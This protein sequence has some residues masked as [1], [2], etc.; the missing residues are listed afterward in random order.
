MQGNYMKRLLLFAL[1]LLPLI[2]NAEDM[3]CINGIYYKFSTEDNS[4]LT[5]VTALKDINEE[6]DMANIVIPGAL[7][8][9]G[10]S[11]PV[12]SISKNA[13]KKHP[14]ETI[15]LWDGIETIGVTAFGECSH[16]KSIS[17]PGSVTTIGDAAF[18]GC[19]SLESIILPN[20]INKIGDNLFWGCS[21]LSNVTLPQSLT[22]IGEE[23][24]RECEALGSIT[25]PDGV[26]DIGKNAFQNCLK[27]TDVYCNAKN[28]PKTDNTAFAGTPIKSATLHVPAEAVEAYR[29]TLPWSDF[30]EI[31]PLNSSTI[32][33][34]GIY[35]AIKDDGTLEVTGLATSVTRADILSSVTVN[36][37]KYRV[38]SIAERAFE[39]RSDLTYLSVPYSVKSIGKY[40]FM[41]C[42][43]KVAVNIADPESWCQMELGNES[44]SPLS[45]AGK[46]LVF[47]TE[48]SQVTIPNSVTSINAF[49]FYQC[50]CIKSLKIPAS[51]TSIGSSAF[52]GCTKLKTI[53]SEIQQPFA[54]DENVFSTWSTATLI[55]PAGKKSAYKSA[56]GWNQFTHIVEVGAETI[57]QCGQNA[58]YIYDKSAQTLTVYGE[59]SMY[60]F[61]NSETSSGFWPD[62]ISSV[63]IEPGV[64]AIGRFDFYGN[65]DLTSIIIPSSVTSIG[66]SA[67][68]G[69]TGLRSVCCL[70]SVPPTC[71]NSFNPGDDAILW[72]PQGC[73]NAYKGWQGF[74]NIRELTRGDVN[75]DFN[76]N[77]EDL[78]AT[79]NF[80]MGNNSGTFYESLADL[81]GDHDVNAADVVRIVTIL[82]IQ[83]GLSMD[84]QT[85]YSNLFVSSLKCS[86]INGG[87]K[88]IQLT[89]CELFCNNK[90]IYSSNFKVTLTSG[91][92]KKCTFDDLAGYEAGTG[93]SVVWHYTINGEENTYNVNLP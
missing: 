79:V 68:S 6:G 45:C 86:L 44:S 57:G 17:M 81:N 59:G 36:G 5:V 46:L 70:N 38:T 22:A 89:E 82:D 48:T 52:E 28:V 53:T 67:F 43:N 12:S 73:Q 21:K 14:L 93:W 78:N 47:D 27:L 25:I 80:I 65:T 23:A 35:F 40:A 42:G 77:Q 60:G 83:A 26:K 61:P 90:L 33:D 11:Y 91:K 63:I 69:C 34:K 16:L 74:T 3:F 72:V 64:T 2:A 1:S 49:T 39:G 51:V 9:R 4:K 13:F 71:D 24:F 41:N 56:A 75:I 76:V 55:V 84:W 20:N 15:V 10:T 58:N 18:Y 88:A 7:T 19:S 87:T 29:K 37:K 54:I 30:K 92:N 8:L 62:K 31:V 32:I 66:V 50:S 85:S